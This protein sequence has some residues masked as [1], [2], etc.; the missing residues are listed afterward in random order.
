V[1]IH[2]PDLIAAVVTLTGL[3]AQANL[4]RA[5]RR[6]CREARTPNRDEAAPRFKADMLTPSGTPPMLKPLS[7]IA[8]LAFPAA[9]AAAQSDS[10]VIST[11]RPSFSDGAGLQPVGRLNLETGYTYTF[12]NREDVK[13]SRHN[14]PEILARVGVLED[15]FEVRFLTSGYVWTHTDDRTSTS[16][17]EGWSDVALGIKLKLADQSGWLPRLALGALT[18]LGGGSDNISSQIAEPTLK[19]IWAYDLGQSFGDSWKGFTLGG[20]ANVSWTTTDGDRYA[21]GQGSIYLSFPLADRLSGFVEY[22]VLAPASKDGHAAHSADL[23]GTYLL[24][25]RVQL[26]ARVG[27]GLNQEA[28]NLFVGCG[29]SFLF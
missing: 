29:V 19:L 18:T 8:V 24:T 1:P 5:F 4:L 2:T 20:N 3:A 7:L 25:D 21:Q 12:R 23:G 11:D 9:H 10:L 13:T 22:Y 27:A 14:G 17:D 6:E 16:S 28:D 26:D 15:R